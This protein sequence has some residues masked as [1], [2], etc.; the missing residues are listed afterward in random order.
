MGIVT[1][2]RRYPVKSM[3]GEALTSVAVTERGLCEDRV[4][5]V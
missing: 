4:S 3:L 1:A 5:A 2:L